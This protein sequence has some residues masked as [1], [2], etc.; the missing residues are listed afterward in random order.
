M[1]DNFNDSQHLNLVAINIAKRNHDAHIKFSDGKTLKIRDQ[2]M[3]D[4]GIHAK[5]MITKFV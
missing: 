3:K 5:L 4:S 1:T 2:V